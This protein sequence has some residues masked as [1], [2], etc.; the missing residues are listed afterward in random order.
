MEPREAVL[1]QEW[2]QGMSKLQKFH[3]EIGRSSAASPP[4]PGLRVLLTY[5]LTFVPH[6]L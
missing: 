4:A 5:A 3:S 6:S 1:E 2:A